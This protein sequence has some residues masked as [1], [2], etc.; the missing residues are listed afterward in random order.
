MGPLKRRNLAL[1]WL[2]E[3]T[4]I[5]Q[6]WLR[7]SSGFRAVMHINSPLINVTSTVA[8]KEGQEESARREGVVGGG[9]R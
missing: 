4:G 6:G 1:R 7:R 3:L 8:K 5:L 2:Q 9:E